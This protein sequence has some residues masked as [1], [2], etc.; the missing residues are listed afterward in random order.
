VVRLN[1]DGTRDTSTRY[2][3]VAALDEAGRAHG[4]GI[5]TKV[6]GTGTLSTE[7]TT[8]ITDNGEVSVIIPATS[9]DVEVFFYSRGYFPYNNLLAYYGSANTSH[10][11]SIRFV[12]DYIYFEEVA[13]DP[14]IFYDSWND[15]LDIEDFPVFAD[16]LNAG[17][18]IVESIPSPI[19]IL[20]VD[21]VLPVFSFLITGNPSAPTTL[22]FSKP[23]FEYKNS[24]GEFFTGNEP[25]GGFLPDSGGST[26]EGI[27][28]YHWGP[29]AESSAHTNFSYYTLDFYRS[30][31]ITNYVVETAVVPV[32]L[33]K[34][35]DYEINWD[36]LE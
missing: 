21:N 31:E 15:D 33:V 23:L 17:R 5:Y 25:L 35:T 30:K 8:T 14:V 9:N 36:V 32:N 2:I 18:T 20:T 29:N 28:D 3:S 24:A 34:D 26:G 4:W 22:T 19:E 12:E 10:P 7:P 16:T 1:P 27:Y 11:F 13:A 6:L